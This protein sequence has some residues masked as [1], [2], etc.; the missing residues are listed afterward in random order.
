MI[1]E[2]WL[3]CREPVQLLEYI[4]ATDSRK[5][6]ALAVACCRRIIPWVDDL[7]MVVALDAAERFVDG[8]V[9]ADLL[10]HHHNAASDAYSD[11]E[12]EQA[13]PA[14]WCASRPEVGWNVCSHAVQVRPFSDWD[15][16]QAAQS[17]LVRDIFVNPFRPIAL[18]RA[19]LTATVTLLAQVAYD[20]R[21]LP[22]GHL[23]P[24]R[25][26]V[27]ADALEEAGCTE[28]GIVDHFH[29]SGPHVRGCWPL[30]LILAKE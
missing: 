2:D 27:L 12:H 15:S 4:D 6:R 22:S 17:A 16:E 1:E 29:S 28:K 18:D 26:A 23:D 25:L 19:W 21:L 30:D 11:A 24:T 9:T 20:E 10:K 3:S 7:R 8:E 14:V 13:W 5:L